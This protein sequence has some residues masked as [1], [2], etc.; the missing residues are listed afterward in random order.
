MIKKTLSYGSLQFE[1][2]GL[3]V[4]SFKKKPHPA[5]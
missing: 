3:H 5:S 1:N 2:L 4:T